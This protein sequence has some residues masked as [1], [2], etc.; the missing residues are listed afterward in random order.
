MYA[1]I[2]ERY[3]LLKKLNFAYLLYAEVNITWQP[4]VPFGF[5]QANFYKT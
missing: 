5:R 3:F 2:I 4:M 1:I